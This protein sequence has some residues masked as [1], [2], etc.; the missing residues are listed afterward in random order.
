MATAALVDA[1]MNLG[2]ELISSLQQAGFPVNAALWLYFPEASEWRFLIAT[3]MVDQKGPL[4]T[5]REVQ[6]A[7]KSF[8]PSEIPLRRITVVGPQDE[9]VQALRSAIRTGAGCG[10][11]ITNNTINNFFVEDAYIYRLQAGNR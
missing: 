3:P 7:L 5:Y 1:E 10:I 9:L 2:R 8:V 4:A 6:R 11:R